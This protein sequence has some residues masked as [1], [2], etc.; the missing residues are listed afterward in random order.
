MRNKF[1]TSESCTSTSDQLLWKLLARLLSVTITL[2]EVTAQRE[3]QSQ[4]ESP[5]HH[6][7]PFSMR[8]C[9]SSVIAWVLQHVTPASMKGIVSVVFLSAEHL[10]DRNLVT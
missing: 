4:D 5:N 2:E 3:A 6:L 1:T 10:R 7:R 8:L 9:H